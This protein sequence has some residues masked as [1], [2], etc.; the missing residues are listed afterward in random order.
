MTDNDSPRRQEAA[1]S[2]KSAKPALSDTTTKSRRA[3]RKKKKKTG[4]EAQ[5]WN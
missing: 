2:H 5:R 4:S 1:C 3:Q